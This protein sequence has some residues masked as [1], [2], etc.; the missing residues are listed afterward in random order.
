[1]SKTARL[2]ALER[3]LASA[4]VQR[5]FMQRLPALIAEL[6]RSMFASLEEEVSSDP[7]TQAR[8]LNGGEDDD[9]GR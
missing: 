5:E 9:C 7:H 8:A 2:R 6:E 4:T 1:M 3:R